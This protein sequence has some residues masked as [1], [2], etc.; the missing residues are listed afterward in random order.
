MPLHTERCNPFNSSADYVP[1]S[2][3]PWK[4]AVVI[5]LSTL[6]VRDGRQMP[7]ILQP[8]FKGLGSHAQTGRR[9][10]TIGLQR[11]SP[12]LFATAS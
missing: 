6:S 10:Q 7:G 3:F 11:P 2:H 4:R 1:F 12:P 9:R 5:F 8:R